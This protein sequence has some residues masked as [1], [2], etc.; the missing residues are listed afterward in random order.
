MHNLQMKMAFRLAIVFVSLSLVN[1][2]VSFSEPHF[3]TQIDITANSNDAIFTDLITADLDGDGHLDISYTYFYWNEDRSCFVYWCPNTDGVGTFADRILVADSVGGRSLNYADI[4][5]DQDIDLIAGG[6]GI[7]W[8]ENTD[9]TGTF[10]EHFVTETGTPF[11]VYA[12]D[13]DS[14]EDMDILYSTYA[15]I[16]YTS[17]DDG[18]FWC[19]NID[20]S[21][22]FGE[23]IRLDHGGAWAVWASPA[24]A[25]GDG[26]LD[27]FYYVDEESPSEYWAENVDGA[28][29]FNIYHTFDSDSTGFNPPIVVADLDSDGDVDVLGNMYI[30]QSDG[31]YQGGTGWSENVDG[32]GSFQEGTIIPIQELDG[33]YRV[34]ATDLDGDGD[35]D[36]IT[37][38]VVG[39][40]DANHWILSSGWLENINGQGFFDP[41]QIISDT[42]D[43]R[44]SADL[45]GDGDM[46][47]IAIS[48]ENIY[49]LENLMIVTDVDG[50]HNAI[51]QRFRLANNYP[52][53][54][55][56]TTTISYS[57]PE[58]SVVDLT[59]FDILG[60]EVLT[61][62]NTDQPKGNYQ[63]YWNGMDQSGNQVSTGVYFARLQAR[64]Y[65]Q[66]IK[67]VYLR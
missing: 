32:L 4:D 47:L 56:P 7:V 64:E 12:V 24:D 38:A 51:P 53:P 52:N 9:G 67:M 46:D 14:D 30:L 61:L 5:E 20:G 10:E 50:Q 6:D 66:T 15:G 62:Q 49:W 60:R 19:P 18:I 44:S 40:F 1:A 57:L 41:I 23:R 36:V 35:M 37:S 65:N 3:V 33:P 28:G 48:V 34:N 21:G 43:V 45:D 27:V 29:A 11:T 54:F 42:L 25:D 22:A 16:S 58:Q 39:V 26:D 2:Q 8:L 13:L 31:S 59:V 17:W 55:N 63:V